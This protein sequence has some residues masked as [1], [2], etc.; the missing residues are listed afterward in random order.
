MFLKPKP[1]KDINMKFSPGIVDNLKNANQSIVDVQN[2][3]D[4]IQKKKQA[5][6]AKL[7]EVKEAIEK[8]EAEK[9]SAFERF[10]V[11]ECTEKEVD[12]IQRKFD[13]AKRAEA[14]TE[15]VLEALAEKEHTLKDRIDHFRERQ[16]HANGVIWNEA[17]RE[18]MRKTSAE[19][20]DKVFYAYAANRRARSSMTWENFL[21]S[22]FRQPQK[23]D[24]EAYN[25]K[26]DKQFQTMTGG[27]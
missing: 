4:K 16:T 24:L 12:E 5:M 6:E 23:E 14:R 2:E 13:E 7:P 17:S 20:S 15:E 18:L 8:A 1:G 3:L 21:F 11:D 9:K 27:K 22:L 25:G 26:L 10:L 19:I